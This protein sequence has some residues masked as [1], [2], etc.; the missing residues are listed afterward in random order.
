MVTALIIATVA[1]VLITGVLV[2]RNKNAR[3][4]LMHLAKDIQSNPDV[5]AFE[6]KLEQQ[7]I[8]KATSVVEDKVSKATKKK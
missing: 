5:Q 8:S 4:A 1:V 7:A 2:V 6:K 3:S